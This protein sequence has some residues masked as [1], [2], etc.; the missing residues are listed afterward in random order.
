MSHNGEGVE[1]LP[2]PF[3]EKV[4][5]RVPFD[6]HPLVSE[7]S[8]GDWESG[9]QT[10]EERKMSLWDRLL[11]L[12][13]EVAYVT[14]ALFAWPECSFHP[15]S[16]LGKQEKSDFR[17]TVCPCKNQTGFNGGRASK[18]CHHVQ[19]FVLPCSTFPFPLPFTLLFLLK[20][21]I[22]T[23]HEAVTTSSTEWVQPGPWDDP[24]RGFFPFSPGLKNQ[25]LVLAPLPAKKSS[26]RPVSLEKDKVAALIELT[27]QLGRQ[28]ASSSYGKWLHQ[29]WERD[30]FQGK[31]EAEQGNW[32]Q[33]R[34]Q[35]W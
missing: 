10:E 19:F 6:I 21:P 5:L 11:W 25:C 1:L 2:Q 16:L 17:L 32:D 22:M 7:I 8:A 15:T 34:S 28:A 29:M 24:R 4:L 26:P 18:F 13:L 27:S 30:D 20:D 12:G 35:I 23:S 31:G 3:R 14:P 9:Q 33:A